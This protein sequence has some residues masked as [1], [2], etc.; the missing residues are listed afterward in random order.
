M[1]P[2]N[3]SPVLNPKHDLRFGQIDLANTVVGIGHVEKDA[4]GQVIA[5]KAVVAAKEDQVA[6]HKAIERIN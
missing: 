5:A 4:L 2:K 6:G 3:R 1:I